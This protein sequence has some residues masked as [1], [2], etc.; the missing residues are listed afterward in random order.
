MILIS[1]FLLSHLMSFIFFFQKVPD[2]VNYTNVGDDNHDLRDDAAAAAAK[3]DHSF[4][5]FF[6]INNVTVG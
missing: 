3:D 6:M 5:F 2:K 1:L 4:F